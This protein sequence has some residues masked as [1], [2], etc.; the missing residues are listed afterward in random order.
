VSNSL[1]SNQALD[2]YAKVEDLLGIKE[3][4]PKLYAHYLLF[5]SSIEYDSILDVGCGSGDFLIQMSSSF[6]PSRVVGIDL[7]E[8]M[9]EMSISK[10]IDAKAIDISKVDERFDVVT[11]VFDMLNYLDKSELKQ[12][13]RSIESKINPNGYLICDI[14][15]IYGFEDIAVGSFIVDDD[16]RFLT[17]DSEYEDDI[18]RSDFT[19]FERE[20]DGRFVKSQ[21]T[22]E[23]RYHRVR[24]ID[25]M[26]TGMKLL[27]DD[28]VKI[29]GDRADKRFLVFQKQQR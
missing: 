5:L 4:S 8:K 17:I 27:I 19:L 23:Q 16:D 2:L 13:L 6:H 11:A 7:S 22:I 1:S 15:T 18:Y 10:G 12:L 25:E 29:Y 3:A 24:E 21:D 14:N 9:V 28:D 26:L 20:E